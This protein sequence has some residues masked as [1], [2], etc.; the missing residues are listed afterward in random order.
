[1]KIIE[2][3][4]KKY[5][6]YCEKK[7]EKS[8]KSC[9]EGVVIDEGVSVIN[10]ENISVGDHVHLRRGCMLY[11]QGNTSGDNKEKQPYISIGNNTH[12]KENAV[13]NTYGG[14]IVLGENVNIGQGTVL[15][16]QGGIDVGNDSG[17]A[18]LSLVV[19]S[20]HTYNQDGVPFRM[21]GETKKGIKIGCNVW[22]AGKV[23]VCDGV[24]IGDNVVVGAGSVVRK[25]IPDNAIVIGNPAQIAYIR[26]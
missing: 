7:I 26:E 21:Q 13:L 18:P 15:Y 25:N 20:N 17:I 14:H 6:K 24:E 22:C 10:P 5:K 9:G 8:F 3:I 2:I 4:H 16:G 12:I 1:M 23:V 11:A 19:A